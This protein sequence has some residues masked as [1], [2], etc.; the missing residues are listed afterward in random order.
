[1]CEYNRT[2]CSMK[3]K[4]LAIEDH[5]IN[6]KNVIVTGASLGF[7]YNVFLPVCVKGMG[8]ECSAPRVAE[9]RDRGAHTPDH[10]LEKA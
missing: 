5:A 4:L 8:D 6:I 7:F 9:G 10:R 2:L 3:S 1:M